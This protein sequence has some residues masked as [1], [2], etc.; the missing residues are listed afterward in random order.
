M[1]SARNQNLELPQDGDPV[2]R[3]LQ[4]TFEI[5]CLAATAA[6]AVAALLGSFVLLPYRVSALERAQVAA[7]IEAAAAASEASATRE[8]VVRI[9]EDVKLLMK[10]FNIKQP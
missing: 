10:T 2:G 6:A 3:S 4:R 1:L 7:K 8:A 9:E 5:V